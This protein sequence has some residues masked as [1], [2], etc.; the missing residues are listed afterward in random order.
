MKNTILTAF[1]LLL[2]YGI[3]AQ[4]CDELME[5]V[6]SESYGSTYNSPSSTAISKVTFYTTTIDYQ[7]YYFAI[8]CFKKNEYSY[9]CSE[10]LYQVASNTKLN[11]SYDYL[12]SAGKAF[13]KH[14]QP[15]NENLG[16][17]PDF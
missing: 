16:C 1:L 3:Q 15:Y 11:Y 13:W 7:T 8:V 17:A 6:K 4:S 10:Y 2:T 14:I 5:F 12:N 9:N